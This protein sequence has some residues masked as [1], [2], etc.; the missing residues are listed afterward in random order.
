[1]NLS[2]FIFFGTQLNM[3]RQEVINA[4]FGEMQDL[5]SCLSVYNGTAEIAEKKKTMTFDEIMMMD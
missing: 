5:I 1:M 4:R 2:W 3:N